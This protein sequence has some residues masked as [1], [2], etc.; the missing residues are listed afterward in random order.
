MPDRKKVLKGL[1]CCKNLDL[2]EQR[3]PEECPYLG[4]TQ[5]TCGLDPMLDDAIELLEDG[6]TQLIYRDEIINAY[7]KDQKPV[8]PKQPLTAD[9]PFWLCGNCGKEIE[10]TMYR[11]C[12]YCGRKVKWDAEM[13]S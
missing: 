11:Y 6:E 7:E 10:S 4:E 2:S 3:C 1:E 9:D 5:I 8:K 12:P 13:S